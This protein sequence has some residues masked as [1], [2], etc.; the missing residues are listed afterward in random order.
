MS[1]VLLRPNGRLLNDE[2]TNITTPYKTDDIILPPNITTPINYQQHYHKTHNTPITIK[3]TITTPSTYR[4]LTSIT[5]ITTSYNQL[6]HIPNNNIINTQIKNQHIRSDPTI[7]NLTF[8]L[9]ALYITLA[10]YLC[11]LYIKSSINIFILSYGNIISTHQY[12]QK[13]NH[14]TTP[15]EP[16]INTTT[17][18]EPQTIPITINLQQNINL[19]P[20]AIITTKSNDKNISQII[21]SPYIPIITSPHGLPTPNTPH[22]PPILQTNTHTL[23][24]KS[25]NPPYNTSK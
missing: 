15:Y 24:I 8:V 11:P 4:P 21:I 3:S 7:D 17:L 2:N 22:R 1:T 10:D 23:S 5:S 25:N 18:D 20:N 6:L 9:L 19:S 16:P 14:K 12:H 13:Y